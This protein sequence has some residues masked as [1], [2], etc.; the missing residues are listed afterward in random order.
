[1]PGT[2]ATPKG[3]DQCGRD[4]GAAGKLVPVRPIQLAPPTENQ[5]LNSVSH[6]ELQPIID[7][8]VNGKPFQALEVLAG[9]PDLSSCCVTLVWSVLVQRKETKR[10][11]Q[12]RLS[13]TAWLKPAWIRC[14]ATSGSAG[15]VQTTE[16]FRVKASPEEMPALPQGDNVPGSRRRSRRD[17]HRS[18]ESHELQSW[19]RPQ[20]ISVVRIFLGFC[21]YYQKY[22]RVFSDIAWPLSHQEENVHLSDECERSFLRLKAIRLSTCPRHAL[23]G[24]DATR[25]SWTGVDAATPAPPERDPHN[26]DTGQ[27][28]YTP[29][30]G[31]YGVSIHRYFQ[32]TASESRNRTC[33]WQ[34]TK[35]W[36]GQKCTPHPTMRWLLWHKVFFCRFWAAP[37]ATLQGRNYELAVFT[38][39]CQLMRIHKT[40]T[41]PA[42]PQSDGLVERFNQTLLNSLAMYTLN[43]Q[44]DWEK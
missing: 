9:N 10:Y 22:V 4:M 6:G 39:I 12:G 38:E 40:R 11:H 42:Y 24:L 14:R 33:L 35:S 2:P 32:R 43:N 8:T 44:Q 19:P 21:T 5:R 16:R 41:T 13:S 29:D 27:P 34:W 15:N 7:V 23:I 20:S 36:N 3:T 37:G 30:D 18:S 17:T 26:D 1:M 31:A 25:L 28:R